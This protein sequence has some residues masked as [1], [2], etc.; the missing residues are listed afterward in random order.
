MLVLFW[1]SV[2]V[3]LYAYAGYPLLL[4]LIVRLRGAKQVRKGEATPRVTLVISAYNEAAVI[5][6]KL[7]NVLS[8][9]YPADLLEVVVVSDASSDGTDDIVREYAGRGVRLERQPERRGKTAGLN[10]VVPHVLGEV[11]VFS[12]A[13]AMYQ[14]GALQM[15]VRNFA[16]AEVGCVTGE[17]RYLEGGQ[18]A[19]DAGER[20]YWN[21]EMQVKRLETGVGSMVGGDGAI[22]AIRKALWRSLPDNAINDFLN[23]LQ[24]VADGWR[25]VYEPEAVCFEETAGGVRTEYRRRIRIVSRSWRAVFQEPRVLNPLRAGF[26][27]VSVVSHKV[28]RWL[29]GPLVMLAG[30]S[31]AVVV[32]GLAAEV[33][34]DV[35][36]GAVAAGLIALL[37]P[38]ARRIVQFGLYFGVISLASVVGLVKGSIGR[39]SGTWSTPREATWDSSGAAGRT[40]SPGV[41]V[42]LMAGALTACLVVIAT[43][44]GVFSA[45]TALFWVS[46][47]VLGYVYFAY[48]LVVTLLSTHG[49]HPVRQS[50]VEPSVCLFIT[51]NDEAAVIAAK[52]TNALALEYPRRRL[53]IL[54]A[55]DGSVDATDAIVRTF[56]PHGVRLVTFPERRGKIAAIND[57]IASVT[58]DIVVFSDANTFLDPGALRALVRN[59]ADETVGAVSGDVVLEGERAALGRSEDLYYRYERWLQACESRIGTMVGVD[60]AL[61][62]IRRQLFV[63]PPPDTILD[64]MAIPMAV[65]R[66]GRRVVFEPEA[67]AHERG[68]ET[69]MEE[70]M[71]KARVVAGAVQFLSRRDSAVPRQNRQLVVTM[72]SHKAL[73]WLSPVFALLAFVTS[74]ALAVHSTS[75]LVLASGQLIFLL[76]GLAGCLPALRRLNAIALAHYFWLVQAAAALGFIRGLLGQQSVAW[77]RFQ[78]TPVEVA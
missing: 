32:F 4:R 2:G 45:I 10:S 58:A 52:L 33:R 36:L 39:V 70:F 73:R 44:Q 46:V 78:R 9:D 8:L 56:A 21:Y 77:R 26:F 69:A 16:D 14:P 75:F 65:T 28:L 25:S 3:L 15:L 57:G 29:S 31:G 24:I 47:S 72:I 37:Y 43:S 6:A 12:D 61:Y 55:S 42:L 35:A 30:V 68:S 59:F 41:A 53:E 11:V 1:L 27:S 62:A 18:S 63:P 54:V 60:G 38:P 76:A 67:Q 5:R 19:A 74:A 50:D 66:A 34:V 64:D 23:P 7:E 40:F 51:A 71:R 17:A 13:N 22:Y 49:Q 48:P 20:A